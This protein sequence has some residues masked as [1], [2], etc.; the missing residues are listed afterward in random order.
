MKEKEIKE[1]QEAKADS[2]AAETPAPQELG[3]KAKEAKET[4][5]SQK[6]QDSQDSD[7][8]KEP[9]EEV[10]GE[11]IGRIFEEIKHRPLYLVAR[12]LQKYN[13]INENKAK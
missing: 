12:H 13:K 4:K 9:A 8:S 10:L 6:P 5:A 11:Y 2:K 1:D 3:K 7:D